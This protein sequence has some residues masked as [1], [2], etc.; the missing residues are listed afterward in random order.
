MLPCFIF[1]LLAFNSLL[2]SFNSS[3]DVDFLVPLLVTVSS[4]ANRG[5]DVS[6]VLDSDIDSD[7][8]LNQPTFS[9]RI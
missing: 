8:Q 1:K 3:T 5:K 9:I 2:I 7:N 6:E 4:S